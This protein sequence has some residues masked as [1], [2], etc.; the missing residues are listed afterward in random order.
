MLIPSKCLMIHIN[1]K[2][3]LLS[4]LVAFCCVDVLFDVNSLLYILVIVVYEYSFT[5]FFNYYSLYFILYAFFLINLSL[6]A[7]MKNKSCRNK[8]LSE[9]CEMKDSNLHISY[10]KFLEH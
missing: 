6:D 2:P 5:L 9:F 3:I 4:F 10:N 7:S 8:R 1:N